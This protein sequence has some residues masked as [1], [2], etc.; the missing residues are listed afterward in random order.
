[1]G[2]LREPEIVEEGDQFILEHI[3]AQQMEHVEQMTACF[4]NVAA[5]FS[6]SLGKVGIPAIIVNSTLANR[7]DL[8]IELR[9]SV[10]TSRWLPLLRLASD[11][12]SGHLRSYYLSIILDCIMTR[13]FVHILGRKSQRAQ[14]ERLQR[15]LPDIRRNRVQVVLLGLQVDPDHVE[16]Q[17]PALLAQRIQRARRNFR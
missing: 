11:F 7:L 3:G 13:F 10:H 16:G 5:E 14:R 1:M 2:R 17:R 9:M 12:L 4:D 8:T 6:C 15:D